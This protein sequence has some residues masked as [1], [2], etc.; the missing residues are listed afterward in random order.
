MTGKDGYDRQAM[1]QET[2]FTITDLFKVSPR[3]IWNT[4]LDHGKKGKKQK[5]IF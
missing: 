5:Y 3:I 4:G 1:F 2:A